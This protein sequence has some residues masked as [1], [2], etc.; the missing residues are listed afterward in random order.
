MCSDGAC[1]DAYVRQRAGARSG[2]CG[3]V[4]ALNQ[5]SSVRPPGSTPLALFELDKRNSGWHQLREAFDHQHQGRQGLSRGT[6]RPAKGTRNAL[7]ILA[8][9]PNLWPN[10]PLLQAFNKRI[11]L[12]LQPGL[13]LLLLARQ[14]DN[15]SNPQAER[16]MMVSKNTL[17]R[18]GGRND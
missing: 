10:P 12:H 18:W 11:P 4:R 16:R 2:K 1:I 15:R 5:T 14:P 9:V 13:S 7:C 6:R 17:V 8:C 3:H